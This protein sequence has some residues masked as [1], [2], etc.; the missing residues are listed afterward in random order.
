MKDKKLSKKTIFTALAMLCGI[1]ASVIHAAPGYAITRSQLD[2]T[3]A[4]FIVLLML[5]TGVFAYLGVE[6]KGVI[7]VSATSMAQSVISVWINAT[8]PDLVQLIPWF[9]FIGIFFAATGMTGML[10]AFLLSS[11]FSSGRIKRVAMIAGAVLA[12]SIPLELTML[13]VGDPFVHWQTKAAADAF[14]QAKYPDGSFE[15]Y[16]WEYGENGLGVYSYYYRKKGVAMQPLYIIDCSVDMHAPV[17]RY[18]S[19]CTIKDSFGDNDYMFYD[20]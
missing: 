20:D 18:C 19:S 11:A 5:L 2:Q 4:V 14:V 15:Y 6:L 8:Y 16:D 7:I 1:G 9:V 13:I 3:A 17:I 12:M 10:G